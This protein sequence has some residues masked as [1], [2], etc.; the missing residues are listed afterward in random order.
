MKR[1]YIDISLPVQPLKVP[2]DHS[3]SVQDHIDQLV[4]CRVEVQTHRIVNTSVHR[5]GAVLGLS[6][7]LAE[8]YSLS[9]SVHGRSILTH[10]TYVCVT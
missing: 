4:L 5:S 3:L 10:L 8:I 2:Q 1:T 7:T 6:T 9:K